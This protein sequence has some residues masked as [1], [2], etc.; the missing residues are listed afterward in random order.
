MLTSIWFLSAA[1]VLT[2][3]EGD[4]SPGRRAANQFE[5]DA[6]QVTLIE[7][8]EVPAQEAGLIT[9]LNVREGAEVKKDDLLAQI[10]DSKVQAAKKVAEA[11]YEVAQAEAT[12][13][14]SVRYAEAAAKVAEYDYIA[15]YK[16]NEATPRSVPEAE[17]KKLLLTARKG[18]LETE[19][20]QLELDVAKLTAK[21]KGAA[22]E[23]ADDDIRRRRVL[24]E[25]DALVTDVHLHEG[26]WVNPGDRI[27][28]IVRMDKVWVKG[29][30]EF[31]NVSMMQVMDR[32]VTVS[33]TLTRNQT[34]ELPG[35]IVF[36]EPKLRHGKYEVKAEVE[37]Q[38]RNGA[39]LLVDGM[40]PRMTIDAGMA[41][42]KTKAP[43]RR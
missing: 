36:V 17:M 11:E 12:N 34:V 24:A 18:R 30:L 22:V 7:V 6:A 41:A 14:I 13:D 23:A 3:P 16:A 2:G 10:S 20:A 25:I 39:W 33:V 21:A 27:L 28:T 40:T 32:P 4:D 29:T 5:V 19:K 9:K 43:Q 8:I 42:E 38:E 1:L 37:N 31:A 35:R 15:H 26:E